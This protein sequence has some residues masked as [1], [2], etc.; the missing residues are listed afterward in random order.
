MSVSKTLIIRKTAKQWHVILRVHASSYLCDYVDT[1]L[2]TFTDRALA[3]APM[4]SALVSFQK[5]LFPDHTEYQGN[6]AG[7]DMMVSMGIFVDE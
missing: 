1:K 3:V 5:F 7:Y 4:A 2:A 6:K